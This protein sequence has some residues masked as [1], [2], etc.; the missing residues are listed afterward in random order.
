MSTVQFVGY[1][2]ATATS[3]A[4]TNL[5][6]D[7]IVVCAFV[8]ASS[9]VP[10]L[11]GTFTRINQASSAGGP[12][13]TRVA[14]IVGWRYATASDE[15]SGVWAGS[16]I[17]QAMVFRGVHPV[18]PI[19]NSAANG[20]NTTS[21]SIVYPAINRLRTDSW[22]GMF[23]GRLST[24]ALAAVANAPNDGITAMISRGSHPATPY[25]AGHAAL[26]LGDWAGAS[27]SLT[28]TAY[29]YTSHTFEI[30]SEQAK[31]RRIFVIS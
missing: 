14:S 24:G 28:G 16:T 5:I 3:V 31:R 11:N 20:Q 18:A 19:G 26:S 10:S 1:H 7:L 30:L 4:T 22:F 12:N 29:K 23:G 15:G 21:T 6:G 8:T 17:V 13:T 25:V 2:S 9:T 27:V